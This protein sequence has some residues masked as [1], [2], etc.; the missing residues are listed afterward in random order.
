[1][2]DHAGANDARRLRAPARELW[3]AYLL[4]AQATANRGQVLAGDDTAWADL[5]ARRLGAHPHES[6]ALFAWLS[7]K[8]K[9]RGTRQGAQLQLAYSLYQVG[10]DHAA[11]HLFG[12]DGLAAEAIDPRA[13]YL[14][15]G[16][17]EKRNR[18]AA[19][20]RFWQGLAAPADAAPGEW[21][22]RL[23]AMQWR[24][25]AADAA[26]GTVRVLAKSANPLP[27]QAV[28]RAVALAREVLAAGQPAVAEEMLAALLPAAGREHAREMLLALGDSAQS[29]AQ[30]ARA[31]DYFLRAALADGSRATDAL[32]LRAR[33]AAAV[34]LARAGYREDARAQFRWVIGNSKVAA[35]LELA[36]RELSR[37]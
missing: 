24:S 20:V 6:R 7:R 18:P 29:A 10:L 5:A 25:G 8:G 28:S 15:G 13:R 4:E 1:M 14:L 26:V 22:I 30:F 32:A 35:Q 36:R 31:A 23:A 3:Q 34:N 27:V 33:L 17:A 12:D 19:A 2:L 11:L 37:L 9:A 21:E 16:I